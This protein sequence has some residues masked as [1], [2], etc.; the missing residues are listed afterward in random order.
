[1]FLS[2]LF[3]SFGYGQGIII[4]D[5][6]D[7]KP[8][9][10]AKIYLKNKLLITD[11]LGK[12]FFDEKPDEFMIRTNGY[13]DRNVSLINHMIKLKPGFKDISEIEVSRDNF[14]VNTSIGFQKSK[15]TIII[16]SNKEFAI[17]IIHPFGLC[18]LEGIEIPFKKSL[19]DKGY[20]ILDIYEENRSGV[21]A[22]LNSNSYVVPVNSLKKTNSVKINEK[23]IVESAFYVSVI[24]VENLYTKSNQF[25]NKI[26]LN[27]KDNSI[28]GKMFVRKSTYNLWDLKTFEENAISEN[29]IIPAFSASAKCAK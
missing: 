21:G 17:R 25:T 2:L 22:R 7:N 13:Q 1:M 8:V 10:H 11:S 12:Y 24:W 3:L 29:S 28:Q 26:Y 19:H 14:N 20:L 23:I 16:D 27:V 9:A 18:K 4:V 6:I 15:K 5:S